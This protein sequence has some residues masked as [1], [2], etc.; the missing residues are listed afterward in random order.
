M[1][2]LVAL[3]GVMI[4]LASFRA[5]AQDLA[6]IV[7][8]I[9]DAT[10]AVIPG[11]EVTVTNADRGF[12]RK[13][14]SDSA[15]EY[16]APRVP[17]GSYVIALEKT[18][19]QKL[20]RGGITLQVG[21]TLRVDLQL[22]VGS[23]SQE[24]SVN[25]TVTHVETETSAVSDVVTGSQVSQLNLNARNFA[26]LATLVPGAATVAT[27]FDTSHV[28]PM[29]NTGISFNGLPVNIENWEVD[30]TNN[31]DQGSGSGS[32]QT[33]P[34]IDSIAEFRVSTANYSA[35][36]GKSG[37][38]NI[39]VVTKSGSK[40]FHGTM[41]E[42]VRNDHFDANDWFINR[43]I[44]P[45]GGSAPKTPL[46][47]NN[48]G[49]TLGGPVFIP[50]HYNTSRNKTFFFVSEEWRR[51]REGTVISQN[52]PTLRMH[53]GDFSECDATSSNYNP[54][55]ASGCVVPTNPATNTPFQNDVVPMDPT[56]AA[57][58]NGLVPLPNN[59]INFYTAAP[60]IPTNFRED[61]FKIDHNI[62]DNVRLFIR[63]T[64]DSNEQDIV[65]TVW[66]GSN[67]GTVETRLAI[68]TKSV[69]I[70]LTQ[71]FTSNVLNEFIASYSDD[72]WNTTNYTGF[73]SP[74]GSID[75]PSGFLLKTIFPANQSD[76]ILPGISV[77]GGIPSPFL[78]ATGFDY[79]FWDPQTSIKDN[80]VWTRGAHSLKMGFFLLSNHIN[81]TSNIVND[82]RG[83]ISFGTGNGSSIST[84]NGL[85]D[86]FLGR[87][88]N[89]QEYGRVVNGNLLGGAEL[90]HYRQ[91][92]F[93][94][95]FQ[96]DWHVTSHLTLNLGVR[97]Y[98]L[99]SFHDVTKPTNDSL[100]VPSLYNPANEA[101]LDSSGYLIPGTG[102]NYLNYGNGLVECGTG[103]VPVGCYKSFRGTVSPRLGFSWDPSGHG[104][105]AIR[106]GYALTWDNGNPLQNA[107]GFSG[108]PPTAT[109]LF[110]Y[111]ILGYDN[112][113][114]GPLGPASFSNM[115]FSKWQEIQ[116]FNLGV[117]HQFPGNNI[118]SVS[119]VG[120]LGRHIQQTININQVP[121]GVGTENVPA[122]AGTTGCDAQGNCDVQSILMSD[123]QSTEFFV[124]YRGWTSIEQRQMTGNSNYSSLQVNF[125]HAFGRG[126][127]FQTTYTWSHE[128]DNM[129]QSGDVNG[130]PT[131]GIN[132]ENLH[133]WYGTGGLN[134]TQ[135]L[136]LNYVYELPFLKH[137]SNR[138]ARYVLSGWQIG[139]ISSFLTGTPLSVTCGINGMS[140]GIGGPTGCNSLGH[141]SIKKGV[142]NDPQFGPTPTWFDPSLLGQVTVNQ[143]SA[144]NQPGMFGYI[145]KSALT[146]PG[147]NDWDLALFRNIQVPWFKGEPS[148]LQFRLETY[149]TFNHPQWTG[150]NLFCTGA[151]TPGG[152][153]NGD[154]NI[155]NSEVSSAA[156]PRILQLGLKF[157][158]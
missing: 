13:V 128:L 26:N 153:C 157:I 94:P 144:D 125:R 3:A 77:N 34:S 58:L 9:T 124:P 45:T 126:L 97:Y 5:S 149:N 109:N 87:I 48:F 93:E 39:E 117:Q 33:F 15:G 142:V 65:P 10:G 27:G 12:T 86:M 127:T 147:R 120:S 35:E 53:Q 71:T 43:T 101:Q 59:G 92:D 129:F 23:T 55:V 140:T 141:L 17:I 118:L 96:D 90:G 69:V 54:V 135:M 95:Y 107:A 76:P 57:L 115:N 148:S 156:R 150:V 83:F 14:E 88:A 106:G 139:G 73:G 72:K 2:R 122:L 91:W 121:V 25:A 114:A 154:Q 52:V 67:F 143:L 4:F 85:A 47:R 79:F 138:A 20:V 134:Q 113:A 36:Y 104:T 16:T 81:Q 133:R 155:G 21:Q 158:F 56:G 84:G 98:W 28:G 70:H 24:V 105:T 62:T 19:F 152:P 49:F 123:V 11:V 66:S 18:G 146:G 131:N 103:G 44:D 7:G 99:T 30:S 137:A 40:D 151:T 1:R 64:Q 29:A 111:N 51:N 116:Q 145:G 80:L 60:T 6:N 61:M 63:Y 82:S 78:Q 68:P 38:A 112:V 74:A 41:F 46:K 119:Y 22:Q 37:G 136:L 50:G 108:N 102:A 31:V 42:F 132:D 8:T 100:F 110:G 32:L 89:Y 75:K 130:S